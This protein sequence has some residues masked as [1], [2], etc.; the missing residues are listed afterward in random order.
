MMKKMISLFF[1]CLFCSHFALAY[2]LIGQH[3]KPNLT[4]AKSSPK[5]TPFHQGCAL[6]QSRTELNIN[7]IRAQLGSGGDLWWNNLGAAY[8]LQIKAGKP[9]IATLFAAGVWIGGMDSGGNLKM[10]CSTYRSKGNDWFAGPLDSE[11][12]TTDAETCANWD[13]HFV[14]YKTA[15]D[16]FRAAYQAAPKNNNGRVIDSV[17]F[18]TKVNRSV[19]GWPAIGNPLFSQVHG[20]EISSKIAFLA[21]FFDKN[22]DDIYNP[23]DGDF[24]TT[25]INC[26]ETP[27]Q[28]VFWMFNDEGGGGN[29]T[30]T[31]TAALKIEVHAMAFAGRAED[32]D[33]QN[34]T[35][36]KYR[37]FYRGAEN[38]DSVFFGFWTDP[39]LG[40]GNDD[41]IGVDTSFNFE[42]GGKRNMM[43]I[44]NRDSI[45]GDV[46]CLGFDAKIPV[47]GIDLIEKPLDI[48]NFG[49]HLKTSFMY[50]VN[51][52]VGNP[53]AAMT[54][55]VQAMDYYHYLNC[56]WKDGTPLSIRGSGY[57]TDP[58]AKRTK[59]VFSDEPSNK[60][61]WSMQ[62]SLIPNGDFRT[63]L[64]MGAT[65]LKPGTGNSFMVSIPTVANYG[66]GKIDLARL[67]K[68]ADDAKNY[69]DAVW[70][71]CNFHPREIA[72]DPPS[73]EPIELDKT[74]VLTLNNDIFGSNNYK[75]SYNS[76]EFV[77]EGYSYTLG[78][79]RFYRFEGYKIFQLS[80]SFAY[81]ETLEKDTT[82]IRLIAQTDIKNGVTKIY[83]WTGKFDT[84]NIAEFKY[85]AIEK[86]NGKNSGLQNAF[87]ITQDAFA[88]GADKQL[89]NHKKYY[90]VAV[91]YA[92]NNFKA[93]DNKTG[94]GQAKS[95]LQSH[96]WKLKTIT[97]IPHPPTVP[98]KYTAGDAVEI[99]R[100]DGVGV[101]SH[102]ID[103]Q[104][105]MYDKMLQDTFDG[106]ITYKKGKAPIDVRIFNPANVKEGDYE[107][108]FFD[109]NMNDIELAANTKWKLVKKGD[110][111]VVI[112]DKSIE[113]LQ[114]Q[115]I[116]KYGLSISIGQTLEAGQA[117]LII[118]N[119]GAIGGTIT[120]KKT[121][122]LHWFAA[123]ADEDSTYFDVIHNGQLEDL[124]NVDPN[125]QF[126]K[127]FANVQFYPYAM[128]TY[129]PIFSNLFVSPAWHKTTNGSFYGD[130][131]KN[132][133]NL[134][135]IDIV[136]TPD[137]SKWS[138][139]IVVET[140]NKMYMD[141][142]LYPKDNGANM[143]LRQD[144]SIGSDTNPDA[145]TDSTKGKSWFPG[146]AVDV[147]TGQR[148]AIF[149]GENS[150]YDYEQNPGIELVYDFTQ[151][152]TGADMIWNP[153]ADI[154]VPFKN[155]G[156]NY[157][158]TNIVAGCG[159]YI[160][161]TDIP[162]KDWKKGYDIL[163]SNPT[164]IQN[165][166]KNI[167]WTAMPYLANDATLLSYENGLIPNECTIKLRVDNPYQVVKGVG[168]NNH[169]PNYRFT[170]GNK[171]KAKDIFAKNA[172]N[173]SLIVYPNPSFNGNSVKVANVSEGS[174]VFVFSQDG[175]LIRRL[176]KKNNLDH[177]AVLEWNISNDAGEKV[178][179]GVYFI[180][181]RIDD[182][183]WK[184]AKC[185]V[186]SE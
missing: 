127:N 158:M 175:K 104:D 61:G 170:I 88:Q 138:R 59:Y 49:K 9:A 126:S 1:G 112:S 118:P 79:D 147:E 12:G 172:D 82:K 96:D 93:F 25:Y 178:P 38:I 176:R 4:A 164:M 123:I 33:I 69:F 128:C 23:L 26:N 84:E 163:T 6:P 124:S 166:V 181:A 70:N 63:L 62:S 89:V 182:M 14:V 36:Q 85:S 168:T 56:I 55:P 101:G 103:I 48:D 53:E 92:N 30:T 133:A 141:D 117:P 10:A 137:K 24:P 87:K 154:I 142:N 66:G 100:L 167:R 64:S 106:A 76:N 11:M 156:A 109:N 28:M 161:V 52:A 50:Y 67:R 169:H 144:F 41:Y 78:S 119:N 65:S 146:Y 183:A 165:I 22:L 3:G 68:A 17:A 45:D 98:S 35:F 171:I 95:Y 145:P 160:Y 43:Y 111:D 135:N 140:N 39:Q 94:L 18:L 115:L 184:T 80:G 83:N 148:L 91:A 81:S 157:T 20:F 132:L 34:T 150:G 31:N 21:P 7:N 46:Q 97:A 99:T 139:C 108:S 107:L 72:P 75:D 8:A 102:F 186:I 5:K 42:R 149:F 122:G 32:S 116:Q 37:F 71:N 60:D 174:E 114:E 27:E 179:N 153:T 151:T 54:D 74:I 120:Y 155:S 121:G 40:C 44:Y 105:F 173:Q 86:V 51:G 2:I 177:E 47:L 180:A 129:K 134:N 90:F 77:P 113:S 130:K 125:Q 29:H 136:F 13:K 185:V 58:T 152:P 57:T 159:H 110:P 15:I 73:V 16:S 19:I 162:Y 131:K 143:S